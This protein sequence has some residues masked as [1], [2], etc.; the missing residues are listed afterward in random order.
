MAIKIISITAVRSSF[1]GKLPFLLSGIIIAA[2]FIAGC[3]TL[4]DKSKDKKE[5]KKKT[6]KFTLGHHNPVKT[7]TRTMKEEMVT[8]HKFTR[9]PDAL[10]SFKTRKPESSDKNQAQPFYLKY[11]KNAGDKPTA[12]TINFSGAGLPDVVPVFAQILKFNYSIDP[13]INGNV[14]MSINAELT[15]L[16]LWKIFEQMLWMC[17][18]Y[19][20][21][22]GKLIRI[23]PQTKMSMQQQ[24]GFG[25]DKVS[26]ENVELLLYPLEYADAE[27]L[28]AQLK[29]FT[30][31]GGTFI[32][33]ERQNAVMLVDSPAN[34][35]KM[36][37][38][39]QAMDQRD[40]LNWHKLVIPCHNVSSGKVAKELSE[41]LPVLGF[42]ISL[43]AEKS[44][45][46]A[47]QLTN[48]ERLQVII[49]SA[50]TAEA[51]EELERWVT[52]L[53][54]ADVGEQERVYI[55]SVVNGKADELAQ[56]LSV[57]FPLEGASIAAENSKNTAS[58][59]GTASSKAKSNSN[60]PDGPGSVFEIPAKIFADSVHNRLVIRTTPRSYAM[61]K[62][63]IERLDTIPSQVLLQVLVAEIR[64]TKTTKFGLELM[65]KTTGDG[66]E[67]IFGTNYKNLVPGTGQDSQYGGKYW[68]FNPNDPSQKFG[69]IQALAG[70]TNVKIISS[71]QILAISHTKSKISVG[72][73]VPL[74]QSEVTNSQ[75]VV[76]T[77]DD[78]STS[79]VRN[80]QYYETGV[81]LEVTPHVSR[82][83]RITLELEQTVSEAIVNTTSDIDSPEIR[84]SV[85]NTSLCIGNEQTII[86]GGL[87]REK[88]TDNLDT[89]PF[90]GNIPILR[91]LVGDSDLQI[92]RTELL[93]LITGTI[94]NKNTKLEELL[95]HYRTT[96]DE[97]QKF[98]EKNLN[99]EPLSKKDK[100]FWDLWN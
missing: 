25:K 19:C 89:I 58:F 50:A 27:K 13:E 67:S 24:I 93:L 62:A 3:E 72:A 87:I 82:G 29:P 90:I 94:I 84:E 8:S 79:L 35:P 37:R 75:S 20:S 61:M 47:I 54:K 26:L 78:V 96:V 81:I 9:D 86:I 64:L 91:R 80:I 69:Y 83:G 2:I 39:I 56:A 14:T 85:L 99:G 77:S 66:V 6:K 11:L 43:D 49:A 76:S 40:K 46:G 44:V 5:D 52:I 12:I 68:I 21:P 31:Q 34:I 10:T 59:K 38:L 28:V 22:S 32:A 95:K 60:T 55:Y 45:P 18:A 7:A 73:K 74:V 97:L 17:G 63:V 100:G 70:N 48:L 16:E 36:F 65:G 98:N 57:V 51:L 92:E 53:D 42:K 30:H 1:I 15:S 88:L 4:S 41:L 33:L 71:P 23:L